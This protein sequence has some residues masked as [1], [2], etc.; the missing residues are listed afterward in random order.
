MSSE[1]EELARVL[2]EGLK[3]AEQEIQKEIEKIREECENQIK[4][5]Q[6]KLESMRKNVGWI[7]KALK[8]E[9]EPS[10]DEIRSLLCFK[11]LA[12]CCG[13]KKPCIYRDAARALLGISDEEFV[14]L[15]EELDRRFMECAPQGR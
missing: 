8:G 14:R 7:I 9:I 12:Y 11:S 4:E 2:E 13:L 5:K 10:E 15:K 1:R 6:R 3:N